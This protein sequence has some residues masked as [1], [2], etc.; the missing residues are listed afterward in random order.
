MAGEICYQKD[1]VQLAKSLLGKRCIFLFIKKKKKASHP[2]S[3]P[4]IYHLLGLY[5]HFTL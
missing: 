1:F 5:E 4:N 3:D 2:A